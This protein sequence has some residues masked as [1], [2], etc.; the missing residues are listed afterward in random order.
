M[1]K[2]LAKT[3]KPIILVL[4]EGR[5]RLIADI[6]PLAKAI[7]DILLPGNYGADAL[8][9]LLSGDANFSAKLPYTYPKEI[10]SLN[11]YDYKVSEEVRTMAGAYDYDAKVSLQWPFGYGLSYTSYIYSNLKVDKTSFTADDV[12]TVSVDVKNAGERA[13]K[14]AVLL[15]SS[16]LVASIVPDNKRLRDFAKV[17]LA[18]GETKTVSFKLPAKDLAFVGAD[19]RWTLEEGEFVLKVGKLS[20][21]VQ[22]TKTKIWDT[23]NI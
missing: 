4:N 2:A 15:Y 8:A 23:P 11:T 22:C 14:E 1:V 20:L 5:P 17:E 10:N 13:G 3:G 18:S 19:G 7:V 9:N 21:K 12:L 6:E 16:D